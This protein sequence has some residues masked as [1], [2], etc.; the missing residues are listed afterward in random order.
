[1]V[2]IIDV[3]TG[4]IRI[5]RNGFRLR[6]MAIGSCIV[7]AGY[8]AEKKVGVM[9]HIMLP[10]RAPANATEPTRYAANGIDEMLNRMTGAG[11]RKDDIDV[12]LIG[13]GNVLQKPEDT[14]C[15]ENIKSV[16]QLLKEAGMVVRASALGGVERKSA[17]LDIEKGRVFYNVGDSEEKILWKK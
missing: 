4:E 11:C 13:A 9:A 17:S 6:S 7:I 14:I 3:S 16:T 8:D 5:G 10:G 1:M 12:C 2:E 15:R